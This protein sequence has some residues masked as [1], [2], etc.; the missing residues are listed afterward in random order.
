MPDPQVNQGVHVDFDVPAKMRD[1]VTLRANIYRPSAEGIYPVLLTRL[2]YGK[3]FPLGGSVLD[4]VRAA[5]QG[6]IVVVQDTRCR[7]T[8]EGD[9]YPLRDE[10]PD[11]YDTIE[12]AAALPGS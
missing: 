9:W 6:Y 2:P 7:F 11:S 3:D 1:G 12:W 8:S 4:P 5:R 10:G